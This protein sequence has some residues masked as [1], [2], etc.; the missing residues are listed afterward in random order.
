VA[1]LD[2]L[3]TLTAPIMEV[4]LSNIY[5]RESFRHHSHISQIAT[6]VICGLGAQGY[7]MAI[8]ALAAR[9]KD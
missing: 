6:G 1:I 5:A 3:Q 4:H 2:A 9:L 7:E 8:D